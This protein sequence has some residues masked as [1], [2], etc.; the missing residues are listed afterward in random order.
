MKKLLRE[1]NQELQIFNLTDEILG[2]GPVLLPEDFDHDQS[3]YGS[4][5]W[6][7]TELKKGSLIDM[8]RLRAPTNIPKSVKPL[9]GRRIEI[10]KLAKYL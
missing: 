5:H 3:L 8:S 9:T 4:N 1:I 6:R 2:E 7:S 10:H